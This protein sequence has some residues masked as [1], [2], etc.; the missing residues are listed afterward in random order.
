MY[1]LNIKPSIPEIPTEPEVKIKI[2]LEP[3]AKITY[4]SEGQVVPK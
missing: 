2:P 4:P 1:S 3:E